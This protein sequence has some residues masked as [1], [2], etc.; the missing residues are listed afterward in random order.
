M[1]W[2]RGKGASRPRQL[3]PRS[4]RNQRHLNS[5]AFDF[6]TDR[7]GSIPRPRRRSPEG[8]ALGERELGR[9]VD[10]VGRAAHV[11][12]PGVRA[13]LAAAAGL[14]LAAESAADLGPPRPDGEV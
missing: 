1:R 4:V 13:G 8:D 5:R 6:R 14:L 10:G 12:T 2:W 11:G 3:E 9:V 7:G